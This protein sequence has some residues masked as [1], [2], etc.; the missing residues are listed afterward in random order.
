M[1]SAL[2][3]L[4]AALAVIGFWQLAGRAC[5]EGPIAGKHAND[6]ETARHLEIFTMPKVTRAAAC[7]VTG[8]KSAV[9]A[10]AATSGQAP[11]TACATECEKC[12][13]QQVEEEEEEEIVECEITDLPRACDQDR[14]KQ[15]L[16]SE[17]LK[18]Q[19]ALT[20]QIERLQKQL[21]RAPARTHSDQQVLVEV[22]VLQISQTKMRELG[23][24]LTWGTSD[25]S[26]THSSP[27]P[28]SILPAD[29]P[30]FD[31]L[32]TLVE[33]GIARR[34]AN[35]SVVTVSG[36][37]AHVNVG[38]EKGGEPF[39]TKI[40]LVPFVQ[41]EGRIRCELRTRVAIE[42][43]ESLG[44]ENSQQAS[45]VEAFECDLAIEL[46]DDQALVLGGPQLHR[47]CAAAGSSCREDVQWL[48]V[49]RPHILEKVVARPEPTQNELR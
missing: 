45:L 31:L 9:S 1:R 28:S 44:T 42:Q 12:R 46:S 18:T 15:D 32:D 27:G 11:V 40:D 22:E 25:K 2:H 13:K 36:R 7:A 48:M 23:F 17:I 6:T 34:M 20:E 14:A 3:T 24:D 39:G 26:D 35:P 33:K 49:V 21:Q 29:S 16:L 37:P 30:A 4:V 19:R 41:A 43:V 10:C 8:E 5:A 38:Y 47:R